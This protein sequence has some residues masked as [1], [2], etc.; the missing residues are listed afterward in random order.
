MVFHLT[1]LTLLFIRYYYHPSHRPLIIFSHTAH[2]VRRSTKINRQL[3]RLICSLINQNN[4]PACLLWSSFTSHRLWLD[5]T[6]TSRPVSPWSSGGE[7]VRY[8]GF[9]QR[10]VSC[11]S[12]PNGICRNKWIAEEN[13]VDH[14]TRINHDHH[15]HSGITPHRSVVRSTTSCRGATWSWPRKDQVQGEIRRVFW[16]QSNLTIRLLPAGTNRIAN[17]GKVSR[18]RVG[19]I[20]QQPQREFDWILPVWW[21]K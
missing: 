14:E 21:M 20:L 19:S 7:V 18:S 16:W 12:A 3:R 9:S 2:G 4:V 5:R 17:H 13:R 10:L 6:S 15:H 11:A 8:G 1:A